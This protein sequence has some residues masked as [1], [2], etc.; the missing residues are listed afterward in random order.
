MYTLDDIKKKFE[1]LIKRGKLIDNTPVDGDFWRERKKVHE[2]NRL[3]IEFEYLL[4]E[5][6]IIKP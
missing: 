5:L 2:F 1:E 6:K 3:V 4:E